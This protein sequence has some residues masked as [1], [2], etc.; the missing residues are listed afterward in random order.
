[1]ARRK[2]VV[3]NVTMTGIA[4]RGKAVGRDAEGQVYFVNGAVP[5]DVVDVLVLRKKKTF[6]QGI[7]KAFKS[8]SPDRI[9]PVCEHFGECGGCKWQNL[10]YE[11]QL[12][13]KQQT[14]T[15]AMTR[16]A[17]LDENIIMPII[18]CE[19]QFQYRNKLEYS[20]SNKR[21]LTKDEIDSNDKIERGNAV[22]FHPPGAFDKVVDVKKCHL[23]DNLTNEMR[24]YI[25]EY[26]IDNKL[27][28]FDARENHGFLRNMIFRNNRKGEWMVTIVFGEE[29][30]EQ[31][32]ALLDTLIEQFPLITSLHYVI[33]L[34]ANDSLF[35]QDIIC[36]KGRDHLVE[37]L[38]EVQF[39]IGPKSFFQTNTHQAEMLYK[40]AL[41]F[42]DLK[43]NE[44]VYD[45]YTGIGSIALYIANDCDHVVGIEEVSEAIADANKN[46]A[47]NGIDNATFYAGDVK[48]ILDDEFSRRHGQPDLVITDP[49]RAG[50][51]A[52]VVETLLQLQAP[53]IVYVSC[54]PSTQARDLSLLSEKYDVIK[55]QAV[56]MFPHT[57]HIESVALLVRRI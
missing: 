20:F 1:M 48:D 5:G 3:E 36:F 28:F 54:N 2:K 8:Y 9:D 10:I 47:F 45:L 51:H 6:A 42:A 29:N 23:Q 13:H 21:W 14:V 46:K 30:E 50:M 27:S 15:D 37:S 33:N 17:K 7:V 56:D 44:I 49:P 25:R 38:G 16:L 34:K 32:I 40:T 39:R 55:V 31:R 24:N 41:Q 22:G 53:K 12:K 26:A 43:G 4:D 52:K 18:G 19:R 11:A 57:H 35:D